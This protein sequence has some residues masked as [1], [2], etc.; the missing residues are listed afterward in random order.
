MTLTFT[1]SYFD[2]STL[3]SVSVFLSCLGDPKAV[4]CRATERHKPLGAAGL[5]AWTSPWGISGNNRSFLH[6]S[7]SCIKTWSDFGFRRLTDLHSLSKVKYQSSIA[8]I[9]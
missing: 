3:F 1:V 6:P 2:L 8:P 4:P 5:A 7:T 9:F